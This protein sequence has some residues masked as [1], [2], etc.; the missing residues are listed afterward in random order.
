MPLRKVLIETALS[1]GLSQK[2][3]LRSDQPDNAEQMTNC[4]RTKQGAIRKR[5][6]CKQ[7][8]NVLQGKG[9]TVTEAQAVRGVNYGRAPLL[10]DGYKFSSYSDSRAGWTLVDA[11]PEAVADQRIPLVSVSGVGG[12]VDYSP[13]SGVSADV[14][15]YYVTAF[16]VLVSN[17][18]T[19]I[20]AILTDAG[21]G[22]VVL[23]TVLDNTG[24]SLATAKVVVCG[25]TAVATWVRITPGP[26]TGDI[27][28]S[29]LD[30]LN[31]PNGWSA[32][33]SYVTIAGTFFALFD[34]MPM[35]GDPT[36]L[37]LAYFKGANVTVD[38]IDVATFV[39][40]N[41]YAKAPT[42]AGQFISIGVEGA[43]TEHGWVAYSVVT[44][45][46]VH[47]FET[48]SFDDTAHT[49]TAPVLLHA[50]GSQ[51]GFAQVGIARVSANNAV[52]LW[53]EYQ[54]SSPPF[55]NSVW[56]QQ[57]S[58]TSGL[59]GSARKT[60]GVM[61][62][63]KPAVVITPEGIRC[64]AMVNTNSSLQGTQALVCFDFFGQGASTFGSNTP[65]DVPARLVATVAP[66]LAKNLGVSL[67]GQGPGGQISLPKLVAVG[68]SI[69]TIIYINQTLASTG[70]FI[71]TFA[72]NSQV[73]YFG[74]TLSGSGL[75]GLSG[76][77]PFMFDEQT[78]AEMGFLWYPECI[79]NL[80]NTGSLT[81]NFTYLVVYEWPDSIGNIHRGA[82]S[83]PIKAAPTAQNVSIDIPTMGVTWRQRHA[84]TV[85]V[86]NNNLYQNVSAPVKLVVYR[87]ANNGTVYYRMGSVD[88]DTSVGFVTYLD[89][90][91]ATPTTNPLVYTTGGVL[92][93]YCP[94]SAKICVTHKNR[95][96]LG[97]CDDPTAI[98][99]S[100]AL[101][102]G[103]A[104]GFNEAMN[105]NATGAVT[106]M[107]SMDEKLIIFV[108][109]GTDAYGIEYIVGEGP[110]DTGAAN[111]FTNP[112]QPIPSSVGA[113]DQRS[114]AVTEIGC[115]F[116]SPV[117]APNNGG[118][119][120]LLSRDLQV[121]YI[122][123]PV[124]DTIALNPVCTGVSV[125]P[126]NGRIYFEMYPGGG[127]TSASLGVRL[128]YDYITQCWSID[129]HFSFI[130]SRDFSA[131]RC[132]W[133]AGGL[134]LNAAGNFTNMPL[135]HWADYSGSV[136]RETSGVPAANAYVDVSS[137]GSLRWITASYTSAWFKPALSG[138][139]RF[140]RAQ[141]QCD[142]F[143]AAQLI[144][145]YQ[146]DYAP[147]SYYHETNVFTDTQIAAFDRFPQVDVEHLVGNQKAKAIQVTLVDAAPVGGYTTGQGFQW[148]TITLEVGIEDGGRYA[149]LPPGQ[150]G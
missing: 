97:E 44:G 26:G 39:A 134:G 31:I 133:I 89:N 36:R 121:H 18:I 61:L 20:Q 137:S 43:N 57:V 90:V 106:A 76:G 88:N 46:S 124:E 80:V 68:N 114:I 127:M 71:Q 60:F 129:S 3:D 69:A 150:R 135:L 110:L 87:S 79:F 118:G 120:F 94:P 21:S 34:M 144:M 125:H 23:S 72:F 5:V 138:F 101:T 35:A 117:G 82:V 14:P 67:G 33:V 32:P 19:N 6:G 10:F 17:G 38:T 50:D 28:Y 86:G 30:L 108:K 11:A 141:I 15:G 27:Y 64:Y 1:S 54:R 140:W 139:A 56:G 99:P 53:T 9:F 136:Y 130:S 22:A 93:N 142:Q 55:L 24:N 77:A 119:I 96:F 62:S 98:W 84:P 103:E 147:A 42:T 109:R 104:P 25:S 95:W 48:W 65:A 102:V 49:S 29:K 91:A 52:V 45:G 74:G 105:F 78:I 37:I 128:V 132:T 8:T 12:D 143:D 2:T 85:V 100:K 126:T 115:V 13:V 146:F 41:T 63:S 107:A 51:V 111:D 92:E 113:F 40:G 131:A 122:S 47:Q 4:V 66:R 58:S 7:L 83:P 75:L 16:P 149:N 123:G 70:L 81:G 116:M 148:A 73:K 112:P 145:S 59:V